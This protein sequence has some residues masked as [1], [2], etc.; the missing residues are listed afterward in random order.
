[1]RNA[2]QILISVAIALMLFGG[3][4]AIAQPDFTPY[5]NNPVL[6]SGPPG[7]WDSDV[8]LLPEVFFYD[9]LYYMFYAASADLMTLP[10]A[11]GYAT[12][13]D[14]Y[15]WTK[16][17]GNPVFQSDGTGFDALWVGEPRIVR[18]DSLW[19]MYYNA[20]S[21]PGPG[22]GPAIGRA[23]ATDLAGPWT[24]LDNPV[25]EVGSP[26][27]WDHGFV[28][29]SCV[30][31]TGNQYVMYYSGGRDFLNLN[32]HRMLGMAT[33]PDGINWTKYNDP[34]TVDT[35]YVES[36]P[37]L[38][39][40]TP[41]SYDAGIAWEAEVL[42]TADGWEMFYSNWPDSPAGPGGICYATSNDGIHW[43]KD[44]N[45]PLLEP[46]QSWEQYVILA[47]S[48]VKINGTYFM[49]YTGQPG[50][51]TAQIGLATGTVTGIGEEENPEIAREFRLEQNYPN[52][53]N[54]STTIAFSLPHASP[55]GQARITLQV[56]DITGRKIR[57]LVSGQLPP[58]SHQVVWDG[59]DDAGQLVASGFYFYR[60]ETGEGI[61]Q[62]RRM[63]L[64][65]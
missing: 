8:V 19:I 52:P 20:R 61:V 41:G 28:S 45:N 48:I 10:L 2:R 30:F 7:S 25:L 44:P 16:Y 24:P 65:K 27:E 51:T 14:G 56:F 36:D 53:F 38:N 64:L 23:T 9:N 3:T 54:P 39:V 26:G 21:A 46:S 29:P 47:P 37:V 6:A 50:P 40:G 63:V 31:Y 12:S 55:T 13:T 18:V 4:F 33:S 15:T 62:T 59:R 17:S 5:P 60:L 43:V 22:P 58:G 57:T 35:P 42:P 1:M 11:I 34:T 49:Y 32:L